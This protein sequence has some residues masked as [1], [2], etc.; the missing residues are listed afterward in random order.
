M[1]PTVVFQNQ[2]VI[3]LLRKPV[4]KFVGNV[5]LWVHVILDRPILTHERLKFDFPAVNQNADFRKLTLRR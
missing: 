5:R 3:T 1:L 4:L 2:V